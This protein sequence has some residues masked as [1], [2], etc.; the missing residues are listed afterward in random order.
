MIKAVIFDMDGVISDT[1]SVHSKIESEI[2]ARHGVDISASEITRRYAG[3]LATAF[4]PTLLHGKQY[5]L[6]A[7]ISELTYKKIELIPETKPI[8]GAIELITALSQAGYSLAVG[9]S[10]RH[11][12]VHAILN[13][14]KVKSLFDVIVSGD[15]VK[16]TKPAPDIFLAA[17]AGLNVAPS[18]VVVIEDSIVGMTAARAAKM[19]CIGLSNQDILIYPTTRVVKSLVE[20]SPEYIGGMNSY[21]PN[22]TNR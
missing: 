17:A 19:Q 2:L 13:Q 7:I 1:Q 9:S 15:M 8:E 12:Y 18:E 10:S 4:M 11:Q 20:V 22:L 6:D 21:L 16:T 5:D 3:T 14:L